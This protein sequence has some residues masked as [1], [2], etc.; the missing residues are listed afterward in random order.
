MLSLA[1]RCC[2]CVVAMTLTVHAQEP[3]GLL[4][5]GTQAS[6][7]GLAAID[8]K[9]AWVCGTQGTILRTV[10]GGSTWQSCSNPGLETTDFRSIHAWDE[11]HAVVATA[12]QPCAIYKTK[13]GGRQW[14]CVYRNNA[15]EAFLDGLKFWNEAHGMAFGDPIDGELLVLVSHDRG[16]HWEIANRQPLRMEKGEAAFAA[17]NSS[18]CLFQDHAALIGL[19]GA[20][21]PAK[22]L[23]SSDGGVSWERIAVSPMQRG[24]SS[25][26]FSIAMDGSGVGVAVGGDYKNPES[27]SGIIGISRDHGETWRLPTGELP[28][29]YRSSVIHASLDGDSRW[30]AVG[31]LGSD[32]S[33]DGE[34][35]ERISEQGFHALSVGTDGS[36]WACGSGGRVARW[37]R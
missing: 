30:M 23:R 8:A 36:I 24:E 27:K 22:V 29:G 3:W 1:M 35:W 19:G 13:D 31:P 37:K 34:H 33:R 28:G 7:R 9:V 15:P 6:L 18:L 10:D 16:E 17:S 21:G 14:E 5:T 20:T 12:G 25:G 32:W 26:I 2:C 4:P 11:Q